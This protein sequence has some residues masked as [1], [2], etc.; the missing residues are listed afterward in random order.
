MP[1]LCG[2]DRLGGPSQTRLWTCNPEEAF[3]LYE[4]DVQSTPEPAPRTRPRKATM[5]AILLMV[6]GGLGI[7]LALLLLSIVNDSSSSRCSP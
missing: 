2:M 6:F 4:A 3:P 5:V 1:H 7:L